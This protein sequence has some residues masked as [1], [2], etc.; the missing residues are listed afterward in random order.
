MADDL[1]GAPPTTFAPDALSRPQ[2]RSGLSRWRRDL[3]GG[4]TAG[5]EQLTTVTGLVLIVLLAVLGITIVRIGQ[6]LWLHLFLGLALLGPVALKLA[7]TGYRFVRYYTSD[8]V[9]VRKG[10]PAP[11]LRALAPLVVVFTLGVFLSGVVLLF[12]GPASRGTPV[13]VHKVFF[14]AWLAVTAI[15]ILGHLPEILRVTGRARRTRREI[16]ALRTPGSSR[17]APPADARLPGARGRGGALAIALAG[18]LVL[19]VALLGQF[20]AWTH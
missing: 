14:I 2:S 8:P 5:N 9:Y 13:L 16:I 17:G 1:S 4:G 7:S 12:L 6:M 20:A 15:H 18:G 11:A 19:A 3:T 10:P